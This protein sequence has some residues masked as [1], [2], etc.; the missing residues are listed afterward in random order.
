MLVLSETDRE[1]FRRTGYVEVR[2]G[3][4][5]TSSFATFHSPHAAA[6]LFRG[7]GR[8]TRFP[9]GAAEGEPPSLFPIASLQDVYVLAE[10]IRN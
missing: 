5:G 8:V 7:F 6:A 4:E 3:K 1:A 2:G 10:P 9:R